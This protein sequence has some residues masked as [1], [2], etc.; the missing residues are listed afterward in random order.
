MSSGKNIFEKNKVVKKIHQ[1]LLLIILFKYLIFYQ[2]KIL[3]LKIKKLNIKN[4]NFN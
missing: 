4:F 1:D 3:I 2:L